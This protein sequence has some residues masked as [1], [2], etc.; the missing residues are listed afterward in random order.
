M[1]RSDLDELCSALTDL[2]RQ[3][4]EFVHDGQP[5]PPT[6]QP[7]VVARLVRLERRQIRLDAKQV[8][9][10]PL[11]ARAERALVW[12]EA[13]IER[14]AKGNPNHVE[15]GAKGGQ[16]TSGSGGGGNGSDKHAARRERRHKLVEKTYRKGKRD[17]AD[18]RREQRADRKDLVKTQRKDHADLRKEHAADVKHHDA[19]TAKEHKS[20]EHTYGKERQASER[21]FAREHRWADKQ[22]E[23]ERERVQDRHDAATNKVAARHI[24]LEKKLKAAAAKGKA[25]PDLEERLVAKSTAKLKRL[26]EKKEKVFASV[27]RRH[28]A[29]K[30]DLDANHEGQRKTEAEEH[31]EGHAETDREQR[32]AFA[33]LKYDHMTARQ[34]QRHEQRDERQAL[35][36]QHREDRQDY[37]QSTLY[38]LHGE[39]VRRKGNRPL[40]SE[41]DAVWS[42]KNA[43]RNARRAKQSA[44]FAAEQKRR[45][46]VDSRRNEEIEIRHFTDA[47]RRKEW[48][49]K[50]EYLHL[51]PGKRGL[52]GG[53]ERQGSGA[54]GKGNPNHV[55]SG[56]KGGQFAS[57]SG[58]GGG[59]PEKRPLRKK[60]PV[61]KPGSI[62]ANKATQTAKPDHENTSESGP[63]DKKSA[64]KPNTSQGDKAATKPKSASPKAASGKD[65]KPKPTRG[66]MATARR[67]G[68]GKDARIVM[69]DGRDAP[70][71]VRPS[72]VPPKWTDVKV[73]IDPKAEVLVT[74]RDAKGRPKMVTSESYDARSAAVKFGRV[75]EMIKEHDVIGAQIDKARK[76]PANKEEADAAWLMREQG[77]RPG[78]DADTKAKVK[79]YGATTLEAR[80]VVEAPDG[81]RLQFIGKEGVAHD[82]LIRNPELAKM[83]VER[84]K[85]AT[86]T[87]TKI[88]KTDDK[89]VRAFT[90]TLDG[91]KFSPKDFRTSLATRMAIDHVKADPVPSKDQK[92]HEKRVKDVATRVSGVLGNKPAQA[93]QSYIH[94]TAFAS[95]SPRS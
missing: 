67:E 28:E 27:A 61:H 72:M 1:A 24:A 40:S 57:G 90:A 10:R 82:H 70:T 23:R 26:G 35:K 41:H 19:D 18:T 49:A 93:L 74:A 47:K 20:L 56:D 59:A 33:S 17:V 64:A 87:D 75:N 4:L 38:E 81:V 30:K 92:E 83:L 15:S 95:W 14:A 9:L 44:D 42:V 94:P 91:G 43:D 25:R 32:R 76:E 85:A 80:H 60:R 68:T 16:F 29:R 31:A 13:E 73:S 65:Q 78:S 22:H 46:A 48:E 45:E 69:Q 39:G 21:A 63:K 51:E 54:K 53:I 8:D 5:K 79:A 36:N 37:V 34:R 62:A 88:F 7:D 2:E 55:A 77:T 84:K 71:H 89:K 58:G 50:N 3:W 6:V 52:S 12:M 11:E 86:N 66:E